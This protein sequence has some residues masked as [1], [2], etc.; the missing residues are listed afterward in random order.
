MPPPAT[1]YLAEVGPQFAGRTLVVDLWDPGDVAGGTATIFPHDARRPTPRPAVIHAAG[2]RTPRSRP[3]TASYTADRPRP[4][5]R[6][7]DAA[8]LRHD[9]PDCGINTTTSAGDTRFNGEWLR[10]RI[11]I[12]TDY[13]CT[14]GINPE[15]SGG[16]C[17]WG[18]R[19]SFTRSASDVTTWQ[20]RI[21]GNPVRLTE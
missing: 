10:I 11:E 6:S 17:W 16:S 20:A 14:P 15:T 4:A 18:M 13:T 3:D 7:T 2:E 8:R 5:P 1:F 12:P 19:Y 21:E 9:A